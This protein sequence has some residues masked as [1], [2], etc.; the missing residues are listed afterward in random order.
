MTKKKQIRINIGC[1]LKKIKGFINIDKD[2]RVGPDIVRDVERGLPFGDSTVDMIYSEHFMEHVNPDQIDFV[3]LEAWR[4][5]KPGG[6][7]RCVVPINKALM[8]SPYHKS[9][10]NEFT[11]IFFAEWNYK[12]KTGYEF[13]LIHKEILPSKDIYTEQFLFILKAVK[14]DNVE[15]NKNGIKE[16][17]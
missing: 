9:F 14:N 17:V 16:K 2:P 11:P 7:F 12:V 6:E 1:G 13:V 3:M 4:V 8:A 5:L 10:W 15:E